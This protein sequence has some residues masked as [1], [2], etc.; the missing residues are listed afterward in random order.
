MPMGAL[1][2]LA[3]LGVTCPVPLAPCPAV[4]AAEGEG[5]KL[6]YV[7]VAKV[8]DSYE[9]TKASDGSLEKKAKQKEAELQGR[10]EEL[11][12]LRQS[13]E[14]LSDEAREG[15]AREIEQKAE[16]L[17]RFRT[18]AAR[19]LRRE[20]DKIAREILKDIQRGV[21]AYAKANS[22]T[23]IMDERSMLYGM[24]ALDVTDEVLASLNANGAATAAR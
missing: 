17:Q 15:K 1:F 11:K 9:R 12:K 24:P 20:R 6:G 8:F 16:D 3:G 10:M 21:V 22:F 18:N 14:L 5:M 13:L 23:V 4:W 2:L 7:N 19:D